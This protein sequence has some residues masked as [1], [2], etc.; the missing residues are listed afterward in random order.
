MP[1]WL[2][3]GVGVLLC[4]VGL[5]AFS[6]MVGLFPPPD[7]GSLYSGYWAAPWGMNPWGQKAGFALYLLQFYWP[8]AVALLLG[9]M[10]TWLWVQGRGSDES[11]AFIE[12][13]YALE[14]ALKQ[15]RESAEASTSA[16]D[17]LNSK[18]DDLFAR[19]AELWL[20]VHPINGIRRY[21]AN[22][23]NLAKRHNPGLSTLEGRSLNEVAAD[24]TLR[25][26]V[27]KAAADG[28]VWQGEFKLPGLEQW[29]LAWVLPFGAEV[30]VVLRDVTPQ[31]RGNDFLQNTE[32]LLRQ[33][34]E[35]SVRPVAVLGADWRYLY[36]SHK[37]PET[38]GLAAN[39]NLVGSEH[40]AVCPGF[41]AN[42]GVVLQQLEA[43]QLLGMQEERRTVNGREV[44]LKWFIRPWKDAG[45]RLGGYI[46]GVQDVTEQVRL[47]QQVA[48]AEQR[49]NQLAYADALTGLPNRQLFND[50][51]NVALAQAYRTLG[52][53]AVVFLDL[54]GFKGVNDTLGHDSGDLLLKQ[55]A[56][57][58]KTCVRDSDTLARL[59][60]DEFT[61]ILQIREP[62]DAEVVAQKVLHAVRQPY[63][64]NGKLANTVGTS[65]GVALYPQNGTQ[66]LELIKAADNAM[67]DAKQ[68]GKNT[69]RFAKPP[70]LG[71]K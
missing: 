21:N 52:K 31:H 28:T 19:T 5:L 62:K 20:V 38:L 66:A 41:P 9:L 49:E 6:L 2:R 65:I 59:G 25:L 68:A 23:L 13:I 33:L 12:H 22:A 10:G 26:A 54:D 71:K 64:L 67:Y 61:M 48:Q 3:G 16:L 7:G 44:L 35:E 50:R 46:F 36:V 70:E 55:V 56:E 69:Y 34:V 45:G 37:W 17:G 43:G 8:A 15:A 39:Q 29:F 4:A 18:L 60:G 47:Q 42:K 27:Q 14:T 58:L 11:Q 51:L 1:P 57:R 40:W 63:D 53:I 30:A 24:E 32:L